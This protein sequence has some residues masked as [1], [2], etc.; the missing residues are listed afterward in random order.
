MYEY[1]AVV[2]SPDPTREK[3][4]LIPRLPDLLRCPRS[5]AMQKIGELGDEVTL[6]L[7]GSGDETTTT[8]D[9]GMRLPPHTFLRSD[10]VNTHTT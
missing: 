4:N 3:G 7:M 9:L 6:F 8:W 10:D 5:F 2:S 1:A